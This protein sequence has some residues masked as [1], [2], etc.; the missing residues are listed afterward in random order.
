M[1]QPDL[2]KG[3]AELRAARAGQ[4]GLIAAAVLFSV[5]VN[6]LML[7]GPLY[8]LQVYDRVLGSR[9]EATLIAL[10]VI[11]TFM[12][13]IMGVLDHVRSRVLA[14]VGARIQDRLDRRVFSA[15][16]R[17]LMVLPDDQVALAAQRDVE[18]VQRLWSSPLVAALADLPWTPIFIAAIFVLHPLMGWLSV[19]GAILI[20]LITLANQWMTR[21]PLGPTPSRRRP[22]ASWSMTSCCAGCCGVSSPARS[23]C[24]F[25]SP[26]GSI[27]DGTTDKFRYCPENSVEKR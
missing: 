12:F 18:A 11:V 15:A 19:A 5:F 6:L 13:L 20:L 3:Y 23:C 4:N 9:S 25:C 24:S 22:G 1:A 16:L 7:T 27:C 10:S 17:R 14:R 21:G 26:L 2:A 8:M